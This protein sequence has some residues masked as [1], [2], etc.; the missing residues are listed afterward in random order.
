M[1][2]FRCHS[3]S[4]PTDLTNDYQFEQSTQQCASGQITSTI[5]TQVGGYMWWDN[6]QL[7]CVQ[8]PTSSCN[9]QF[10]HGHHGHYGHYGPYG[11]SG[12]GGR[13]GHGGH[14]GH[15]DEERRGE[16]WRG[17]DRTKLTFKLDFPGNLWMAA[18]AILAK[19]LLLRTPRPVPMFKEGGRDNCEVNLA[20]YQTLPLGSKSSI[21]AWEVTILQLYFVVVFLSEIWKVKCWTV[22]NGEV[23]S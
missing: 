5:L 23:P 14:G 18:F 4:R 12:H 22:I 13:Y 21:F 9:H 17:P 6:L 16:E 1:W 11:H 15:G 3:S 7:P 10:F 8:P 19:F 20:I 2:I